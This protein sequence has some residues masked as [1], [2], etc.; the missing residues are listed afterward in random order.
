[1]SDHIGLE[2]L[3]R[4]VAASLPEQPPSDGGARNL[5]RSRLLAA[6]AGDRRARVRPRRRHR[7][8][9]LSIPGI[10]VAAAVT[11]LVV[12]IQVTGP[13]T[14][15]EAAAVARL[16]AAAR[17]AA[18][19]PALAAHDGQYLH[20]T[21]DVLQ[22]PQIDDVGMLVLPT[23]SDIWVPVGSHGTV[24]ALEQDT[25]Y[26]VS[27]FHPGDAAKFSRD[28]DTPRPGTSPLAWTEWFAGGNQF[29]APSEQFLKSLPTE[30]VILGAMM[31]VAEI[32]HGQGIRDELLVTIGDMLR[33][34]TAPP[35][36]RSA[37]FEIAS[38]IPGVHVVQGTVDVFG[39]RGIGVSSTQNGFS[40]QIIFDPTTSELLGTREV[41]VTATAVYPAGAV[42]DEEGLTMSVVDHLPPHSPAE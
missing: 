40:E 26:P 36:L 32:G 1:M 2:T 9:L 28:P 39:R 31:A 30:P 17:V 18:T 42:L 5:A 27:Y 24:L 34:T 13:S 7:W 16:K 8:G 41:A 37:L 6:A 3:Q 4:R 11:A 35:K 19:R 20:I 33:Y 21:L 29:N 22:T 10:A 25:S 14:P 15:A 38:H 12:F 23:R